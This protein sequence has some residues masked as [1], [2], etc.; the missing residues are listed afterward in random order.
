MMNRRRL[1]YRVR[2]FEGARCCRFSTSCVKS[3][4][5]TEELLYLQSSALVYIKDL[6][7]GST[8]L[9]QFVC[10]VHRPGF[11]R[12]RLFEL[13]ELIARRVGRRQRLDA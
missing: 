1:L 6:L 12:I 11:S 2:I 8:A 9:A 7:A 4:A 5:V 10:S 3:V 13:Y